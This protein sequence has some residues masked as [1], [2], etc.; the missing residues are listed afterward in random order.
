MFSEEGEAAGEVGRAPMPWRSALNFRLVAFILPVV[1]VPCRWARLV[2]RIL[3][4]R[5]LTALGN[6]ANH[7]SQT[8]QKG[9]CYGRLTLG[10]L[11]RLESMAG[12]LAAHS[13]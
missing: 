5:C 7:K 13:G 11:V 12:G 9:W 10:T 6:P 2:S 1:A 8:R 4:S 3:L